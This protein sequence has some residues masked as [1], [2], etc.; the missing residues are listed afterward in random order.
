MAN[1]YPLEEE[2]GGNFP[3]RPHYQQQQQQYGETAV[4]SFLDVHRYD[5]QQGG[6]YIPKYYSQQNY[7]GSLE[8]NSTHWTQPQPQ[9][10]NYPPPPV[11]PPMEQ[12]AP[13]L[14]PAKKEAP[15][16][17][18]LQLVE[19]QWY[20]ILAKKRVIYDGGSEYVELTCVMKNTSETHSLNDT[21]YV[22]IPV[23]DM[24]FEYA[25]RNA[26]LDP[27]PKSGFNFVKYTGFDYPSR[28]FTLIFK[29]RIPSYDAP[30]DDD[31]D[32][33]YHEMDTE[34]VYTHESRQAS[35]E[36]HDLNSV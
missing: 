8:D 10:F 23:E 30:A 13:S 35:R 7:T 32:E 5:D 12:L 28:E 27:L 3:L 18:G 31:D 17:V 33:D 36:Q 15:T 2:G 6:Q 29:K 9:Q 16:N 22:Y 24:S 14:P 11:P 4:S 26:F 25:P 20:I 34:F 19:S 1:S 21:K